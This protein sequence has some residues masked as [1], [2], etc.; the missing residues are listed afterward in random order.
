MIASTLQL[1]Q[2]TFTMSIACGKQQ[3]CACNSIQLNSYILVYKRRIREKK[4][5]MTM[6]D[7][8]S[9]IH[10]CFVP[11]LEGLLQRDMIEQYMLFLFDS[12]LRNVDFGISV[13]HLLPLLCFALL[14]CLVA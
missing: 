9:A 6:Y 14:S 7:L 10:C 2:G 12:S 8:V 13:N 3:C 1:I 5:E 11:H 4:A